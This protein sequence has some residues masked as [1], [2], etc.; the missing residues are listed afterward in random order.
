MPKT[1]DSVRASGALY[2]GFTALERQGLEDAVGLVIERLDRYVRLEL[3]RAR[4]GDTSNVARHFRIAGRTPRDIEDLKR[5][6]NVY[7]RI[8]QALGGSE[9]VTFVREDSG[10][11]G[12]V[13]DLFTT[14]YAYVR[15]FEQLGSAGGCRVHIIAPRFFRMLAV[16][17]ARTVLHEMAHAAGVVQGD[18]VE[19]YCGGEDH[20]HSLTRRQAMRTADAYAWFAFASGALGAGGTGVGLRPRVPESPS[21]RFRGLPR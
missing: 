14:P 8:R 13:G 20:E 4:A 2:E 19:H 5:V 1:I 9:S 10:P 11:Y 6:W 15:S 3:M 18:I 17:R 12:A 21:R 16:E 7:R